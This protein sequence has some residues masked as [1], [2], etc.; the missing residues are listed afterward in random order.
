MMLTTSLRDPFAHVFADLGEIEVKSA[1]PVLRAP[2]RPR[3]TL[4]D[5]VRAALLGLTH[6]GGTVLAHTETA[7]ASITFSGTRHEVVMEFCGP[8]AVALG[9]DLIE[10]LPDHE[11]ALPGQLVADATISAVDHR[12]GAMERLEVTAVLLLLEEG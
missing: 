8:D 1:P 12:F 10:R 4:A 6:G 9:E 7:W 3:R 11:F 2:L 5:R